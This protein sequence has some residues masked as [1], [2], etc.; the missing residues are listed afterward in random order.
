ME[1][2]CDIDIWNYWIIPLGSG[3]PYAP[4]LSRIPIQSYFLGQE[5]SLR[6]YYKRVDV[7]QVHLAKAHSH[8][9]PVSYCTLHLL[10]KTFNQ[11]LL[12]AIRSFWICFFHAK[13]TVQPRNNKG[14]KQNK[15]V[16]ARVV[17]TVGTVFP[18]FVHSISTLRD[19]RTGD[20]AAVY[21][22]K[23]YTIER[24]GG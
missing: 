21:C 13:Q 1:L 2:C 10:Q 11:C 14:N 17:H 12:A 23:L 19:C 16:L 9:T 15:C 6:K 3:N 7:R 20:G 18:A 4:R 24:Y 5:C 22:I 8:S